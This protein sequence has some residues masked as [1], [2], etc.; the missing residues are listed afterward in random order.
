MNQEEPQPEQPTLP[1]PAELA[2]YLSAVYLDEE[3]G[4]FERTMAATGILSFWL[5]AELNRVLS[6]G[7]EE[8]MPEP[9]G[10]LN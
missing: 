10:G 5:G 3:T 1:A 6:V 7:A 2:A 8:P 9:E 4:S